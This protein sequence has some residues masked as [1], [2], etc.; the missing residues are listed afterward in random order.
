MDCETCDGLHHSAFC[1]S[2]CSEQHLETYL[3]IGQDWQLV[4]SYNYVP[5]E[6]SSKVSCQGSPL[7]LAS[8]LS[9]LDTLDH[10]TGAYPS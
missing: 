1:C 6:L 9:S 7:P 10:R 5:Y 8:P 3:P 4:K 2:V